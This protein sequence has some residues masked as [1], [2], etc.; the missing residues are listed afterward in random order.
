M[1]DIEVIS[2]LLDPLNDRVIK[3][4]K[5]PPHQFL[6]AHHIYSESNLI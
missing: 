6:E 4:L 5:P 1:V 2:D 3:T